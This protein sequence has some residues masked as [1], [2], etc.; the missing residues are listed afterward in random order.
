MYRTRNIIINPQSS[1]VIPSDQDKQ[2]YIALRHFVS[3]F[4][5]SNAKKYGQY[6]LDTDIQS[7]LLDIAPQDY[8]GA[9]PFS[10]YSNG[11]ITVETLDINTSSGAS[12]IADI[13]HT[14]NS[15]IPNNKF[16]YVLMTEVLEHTLHPFNAVDEL[17]RILKPN[18]ILFL[19]VPCNFRIHG[20]LP[21]SWR[22]THFGLQQGLFTDNKWEWL[23]C[24]ALESVDRALFPIDYSCVIRKRE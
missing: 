22:F 11:K 19:S 9:Q 12:Y 3:E 14:N 15:I 18:G 6:A 5:E 13:T 17:Y 20:P 10:K 16:D 7:T 23:E 24:T 8:V 1:G 2:H 21:D 4:I